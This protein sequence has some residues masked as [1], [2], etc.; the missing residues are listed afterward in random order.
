MYENLMDEKYIQWNS[1]CMNSI[2]MSEIFMS[3]WLIEL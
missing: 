2:Y 1:V 3:A